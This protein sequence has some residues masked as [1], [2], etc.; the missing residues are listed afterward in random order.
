MKFKLFGLIWDMKTVFAFL[1]VL[2]GMSIIGGVFWIGYMGY[3]SILY[4]VV[5]AIYMAT[6]ES[7]SKKLTS[8]D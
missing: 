6:A 5:A 1:W 8:G 3:W 2:I 7:I 4:F